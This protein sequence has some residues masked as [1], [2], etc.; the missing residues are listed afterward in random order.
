MIFMGIDEIDETDETDETDAPPTYLSSPVL[1][2]KTT[3][4]C[5]FFLG[6]KSNNL[7]M[8]PKP[9]RCLQKFHL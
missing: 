8:D 5:Y 9:F 1:L 3:V 6:H 7:H 2:R 4:N